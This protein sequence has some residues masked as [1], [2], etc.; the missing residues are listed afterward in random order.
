MCIED[1]GRLNQAIAGGRFREEVL[2]AEALQTRQLGEIASQI[3]ERHAKGM[4]LVL[5]AGPSS[6]G[7]T[8]FSKRLAVQLMAHGIQ[9][10]TLG[11]DHY[12]VDR[13]LT[14]RDE[15]GVFDF[16]ALTALNLERFNK[17]LLSL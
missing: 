16:E 5:I 14:P 8:T 7:K 4:R 1:V 9:P 15:S 3:A 10:F 12:F 17:D 2:I 11:M 6:A 13:E